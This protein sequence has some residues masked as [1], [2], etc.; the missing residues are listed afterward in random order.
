[1]ARI[2]AGNQTLID[3]A[4]EDKALEVLFESQVQKIDADDVYLKQNDE[5]LK[6]EDIDRIY[7]FAGGELPTQFLKKA[8]ITMELA[9]NKV[10][11]KH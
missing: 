10:L 8:G 7:I 4:I 5:D 1:M 11:K 2:K 6:L 9:K 3:K